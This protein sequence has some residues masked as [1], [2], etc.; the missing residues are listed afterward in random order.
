M[1]WS[2][3]YCIAIEKALGVHTQPYLVKVAVRIPINAAFLMLSLL[4]PFY[5]ERRASKRRQQRR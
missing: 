2:T 3:Q 4:V 1:L 5:G